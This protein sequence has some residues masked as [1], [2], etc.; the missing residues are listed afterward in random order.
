MST[1]KTP[2][3]AICGKPVAARAE[4]KWFPFCSDRC[5]VVDLSKWLSG[6]YRIPVSDEDDGDPTIPVLQKDDDG[7]H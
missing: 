2:K 7:L 6:D 5:K 4:N 3:C 1:P